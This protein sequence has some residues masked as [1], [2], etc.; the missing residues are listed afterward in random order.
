[1]KIFV[2]AGL[3]ILVVGCGHKK[4]ALA[5]PPK[6]WARWEIRQ[7]GDSPYFVEVPDGWQTRNQITSGVTSS[8]FFYNNRG[9]E[10]TIEYVASAKEELWDYML[11]PARSDMTKKDLV[12]KDRLVSRK[13]WNGHMYKVF[14]KSPL[15]M[16]GGNNITIAL[17]DM[18]GAKLAD[19]HVKN[20]PLSL[21]EDQMWHIID[22]LAIP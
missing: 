17:T 19:L 12:V 1:M 18:R 3:A 8:Q 21:T 10:L 5:L 7:K 20:G 6:G 2:I 16:V 13:G 22:S 11:E 9:D 15:P 14:S 4:A